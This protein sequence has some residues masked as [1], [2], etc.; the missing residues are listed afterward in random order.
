MP[1]KRFSAEQI[2]VL[3]RQ[4]EVLMSQGKAAPMLFASFLAIQTTV[5]NSTTSHLILF[6]RDDLAKACHGDSENLHYFRDLLTGL[7]EFG[8]IV[9]F[10]DTVLP[11]VEE[12]RRIKSEIDFYNANSSATA[13][14]RF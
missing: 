6:L 4:I 8:K 13:A 14:L 2:V 11:T 9:G 10:K 7:P 12:K 5:G 1:K 3:L